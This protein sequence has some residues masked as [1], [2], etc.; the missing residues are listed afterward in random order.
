[1]CMASHHKHGVYRQKHPKSF[2]S[3]VVIFAD[4]NFAWLHRVKP[5]TIYTNWGRGQTLSSSNKCNTA[6]IKCRIKEL[7]AKAEHWPFGACRQKIKG[8]IRILVFRVVCKFFC[9]W[10]L[11]IRDACQPKIVSYSR[12]FDR[13]ND[14]LPLLIKHNHFY[15]SAWWNQP[16]SSGQ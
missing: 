3:K 16:A 13:W 14:C 9:T 15:L 10:C 7:N 4:Y 12:D 11:P 6:T 5:N 2:N 8:L 1:M